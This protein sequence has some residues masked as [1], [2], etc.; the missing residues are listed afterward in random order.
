MKISFSQ[1]SV[2]TAAILMGGVLLSLFAGPAA[3]QGINTITTNALGQFSGVA[4]VASGISYI[5]GIFLG[6][7][8]ALKFKEY[9]E[10]SQRNKIGVPIALALVAG[11]LLALPTILT[12]SSEAVVGTG[13][14]GTTIDGS[15]ITSIR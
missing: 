10:D 2:L 15:N 3:A 7:K 14:Q 12:I 8:A 5:L 13:Y 6:I 1:K 4:Q 9:G 11:V